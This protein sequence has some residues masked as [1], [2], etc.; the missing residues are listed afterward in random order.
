MRAL[1]SQILWCAKA[2]WILLAAIIVSGGSF[3]AFAYRPQT[4]KLVALNSEINHRRQEI[5]EHRVRTNDLPK[6]TLE[7]EQLQ[8]HLNRIKEMPAHEDLPSFMGDLTRIGR[9]AALQNVN[10]APAPLPKRLDQYC[11]RSIALNFDGDFNGI[12]SFLQ[13]VEQLKRLIRVKALNI[14]TKDGK[15]GLGQVQVQMALNDYWAE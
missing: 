5:S 8:A 4:N 13:N 1:R 2:Q 3:Y 15:I 7:N 14:R 9:Q 10:T 12:C 11:E 6:I